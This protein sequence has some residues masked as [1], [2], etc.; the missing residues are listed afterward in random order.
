MTSC[1]PP[2]SSFAGF[3]QNGESSGCITGSFDLLCLSGMIISVLANDSFSASTGAGQADCHLY[4][5]EMCQ[6]LPENLSF[7]TTDS[8]ALTAVLRQHVAHAGPS[9]AS[10]PKPA[11]N[12][13]EF[14]EVTPLL[15]A[16]G[17]FMALVM[18]NTAKGLSQNQG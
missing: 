3:T 8:S 6:P 4:D 13:S 10:Q 16:L 1:P 7:G 9:E 14:L 11:V 12:E 2:W 15:L 18:K 17:G 5:D